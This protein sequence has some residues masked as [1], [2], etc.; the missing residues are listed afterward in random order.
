MAST[1]GYMGYDPDE[2]IAS[3]SRGQYGHALAEKIIAERG[4]PSRSLGL[5]GVAGVKLSPSARANLMLATVSSEI[6]QGLDVD[7]TLI[8]RLDRLGSL[9]LNIDSEHYKDLRGSDLHAYFK[10]VRNRVIDEYGSL[11]S[12]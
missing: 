3:S 10:D 7:E 5:E 8:R 11:C 1:L 6:M 2:D 4:F 12:Y 9:G